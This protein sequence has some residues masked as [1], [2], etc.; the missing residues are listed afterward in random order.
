MVLKIDILIFKTAGND[1]ITN[2]KNC[3]VFLFCT[4]KKVYLI[5]LLISIYAFYTK[6][7]LLNFTAFLTLF[8]NNR[9]R[10]YNWVLF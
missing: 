10:L 2:L 8:G 9:K 3:K 7:S 1:H 6:S 5:Y 4:F